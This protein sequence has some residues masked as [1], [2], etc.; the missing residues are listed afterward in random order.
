MSKEKGRVSEAKGGAELMPPGAA[1]EFRI[2]FALQKPNYEDGVGQDATGGCPQLLGEGLQ[3]HPCSL[4][5]G[6][7]CNQQGQARLRKRLREFHVP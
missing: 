5:L 1:L 6:H 4:S 7:R 2:S 3:E